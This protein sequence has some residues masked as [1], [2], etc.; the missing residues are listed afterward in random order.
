MYIKFENMS[1]RLAYRRRKEWG[2]VCLIKHIANKG[3]KTLNFLFVM[4]IVEYFQG[5]NL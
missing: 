2:G 4:K 1:I 3:N 5:W